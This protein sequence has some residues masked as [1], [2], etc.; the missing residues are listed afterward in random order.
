MTSEGEI[1]ASGQSVTPSW[2]RISSF[3]PIALT[4]ALVAFA[5][6]AQIL[7]AWHFWHLTWD[8]SAITLGF[9][10]TFAST[11]RIEPTPGSGIVEGYS[12]TLWMLLMAAVAKI[13][14]S[15]ATLLAAAKTATLLLNLGNIVLIRQWLRTWTPEILANL[16]AG[17]M[18]CELMFYETINGM[19]TPLML[20]LIMTMLL[21]RR[22]SGLVAY[23]CF[24][25]SGCAFLLTRW[26]AA[27]LLLPF[28]L[29]EKPARRT[30]VT[31]GTWLATFIASNLIR[32]RYFGSIIPNTIIAKRGTPYSEPSLGL[33]RQILRHLG[34]V[35]NVIGYSE[36]MLILLLA[37]VL[38][39]SL[40]E[41]RLA[42]QR[43]AE[44]LRA[45]WELR[46]TVLFAAF[47]LFLTIVIGPN[48]GPPARSFYC[49]WP[50]LFCL[51]LLPVILDRG[52]FPWIPA[53]LCIIGLVRTASA[54]HDMSK[55][56]GPIYMPGA[57][58][59]KVASLNTGLAELQ[60]ALR[61]RNLLFAGPD[62]GGI[63][64]YSNGIRVLDLGALCDPVLAKRGYDV[65][66]KYVLQ[67]R[68]PDVIDVHWNWTEQTKFQTSALFLSRYTPVYVRGF[69]L[70]IARNLVAQM[71]PSRLSK[72]RF[73]AD[74]HTEVQIPGNGEY[75]TYG[76]ADY[77]LNHEFGT[78]YI[79]H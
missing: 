29:A 68:Q 10:R 9:A 2:L 79:F 40:V 49:G 25:L 19:E 1:L 53:V 11:G 23:G 58:V 38:S 22:R 77:F 8:D 45:S 69:R 61:H 55:P 44:A 56:D 33:G 60:A 41:P 12:T 74:G 15:P 57:T 31:A 54:V 71:D 52:A 51:L 50:F 14:D 35:G 30:F 46:F 73:T 75:R 4:R 7:V 66:I 13:A 24:A 47:C 37:S 20:T 28:V 43:F 72:H 42:K 16:A 5:F 21:L 64:L 63:L 3:P 78:Y 27:W 62:M 67:E 18:G 36:V 48:W 26:E 6:V 65:A 32:L 59:D 17:F 70:F 34:A 39:G 76:P